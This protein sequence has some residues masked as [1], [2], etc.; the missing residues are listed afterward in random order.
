VAIPL[1]NRFLGLRHGQS[2]ANVAGIV[3]GDPARGVPRFGLTAAGREA[4][5]EAVAAA[6]ATGLLGPE[7]RVVSSDFARARETAEIASAVLGAAP[8]TLEPRL[9]ERGFGEHEGRPHTAYAPVW[10]RDAE[11]PDHTDGGVESARA[12]QARGLAVVRE[13]DA[14]GD[15][16]VYLL[17]SHGDTLQL[18]L[19]AFAGRG[20]EAHRD[21][22]HWAPAEV[23]ALG[24]PDPSDGPAGR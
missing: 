20:P 12:V 10:A 13:L 8:P 4:A 6:R 24:G 1:R 14:A 23:R 18:L 16:A 15:G 21:V 22:A 9:R 3:V 2:E 7:T 11:D 19:A 17:V 5:R